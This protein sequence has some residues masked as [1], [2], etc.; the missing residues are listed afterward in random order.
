MT[1]PSTRNSGPVQVTFNNSTAYASY[2]VVF[3]TV[4]NSPST[5]MTQLSELQFSYNG[6]PDFALS[7]TTITVAEDSA[8]YS[9]TEFVNS[10]TPGIGDVGQNVSLSYT[11]DNNAL[12]STQPAISADGT[13]TFTPAANAYGTA[14]VSVIATDSTGLSNTKTF[15]IQITSVIDAPVLAA[16]T[17]SNISAYSASFLGA[18]TQNPDSVTIAGNGFIYAPTA[19]GSTLEYFGAGAV[20]VRV[21]D[22][23]FTASAAL[24]LSSSMSYSI[25]SYC[26]GP[27]GMV[28]SE[29]TNFTTLQGNAVMLDNTSGL[30][31]S[32]AR[33]G[34]S[35]G[36]PAGLPLSSPSGSS[37]QSGWAYRITTGNQAIILNT[38][39]LA[40]NSSGSC[41]L[42]M[43]LYESGGASPVPQ[44]ALLFTHTETARNFGNDGQY[45]TIQL[46]DWSLASNQSYV[47]QV[48]AISGSAIWRYYEFDPALNSSAGWSSDKI[49]MTSGDTMTLANST[50]PALQMTGTPVVSYTHQELWRFA[51]FGS[52]T[53]DASAADSADPDGDGLSNLMEYAL[54]IDPNASGVMP[55]S[56]VLNGANLEYTY[57]RSTGARENGVTYQIEW[58]DT[59]AADSWSTE[60]VN[61]QIISTQ[62]ALEIVKASV[63]AGSVGKRFLRLRVAPAPIPT[64]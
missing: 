2:L 1:L 61:Q 5:N 19:A 57:I 9:R 45:A 44:G 62:G 20:T 37:A 28:Y 34:V 47:M 15:S 53:S 60:T 16:P 10:L 18:V 12:F 22:P 64:P 14:V 55:A 48:E 6:V 63:S 36:P 46:S 51:N 33:T 11:N 32:L 58:S 54:D 8:T 43:Q 31:R 39:T 3:P 50:L 21:D 4:K 35:G 24:V 17:V 42:R 52:Y 29:V 56:I 26:Y 7:A 41:T 59:L 13:L 38:L 30:S 23:A 49:Y 27:A 40:L 25:R